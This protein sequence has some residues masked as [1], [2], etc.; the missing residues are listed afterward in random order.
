MA[1]GPA[2]LPS[3]CL[4]CRLLCRPGGWWPLFSVPPQRTAVTSFYLQDRITFSLTVT[5]F[6]KREREPTCLLLE[7]P[8]FPQSHASLPGSAACR[9]PTSPWTA[10][11][12]AS[13][14]FFEFQ[15]LFLDSAAIPRADGCLEGCREALP[16]NALCR[17]LIH[18][19]V[20]V[21]LWSQ[22]GLLTDIV[23]NPISKSRTTSRSGSLSGKCSILLSFLKEGNASLPP[24]ALLQP[25]W[26]LV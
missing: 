4:I 8:V 10:R 19:R 26:G 22:L 23:R 12:L 15:A 9:P 24:G 5:L 1:P 13:S 6:H 2:G 3:S 11:I 20:Q 17:S 14:L 16:C 7:W 21:S 25:P 18:F